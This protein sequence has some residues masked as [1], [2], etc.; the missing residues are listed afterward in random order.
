[1]LKRHFKLYSICVAI[2]ITQY[3]TAQ[4]TPIYTSSHKYLLKGIEL[5]EKANFVAAQQHFEL[6]ANSFDLTQIQLKG[7][8]EYY[9][10]LCAVEL[11]NNDAEHLMR[12]FINNYPDNQKVNDAYFDLGKLRYR[13]KKYKDAIYWFNQ[14]NR[15][16]LG[17]EKKDELLFKLGYS[18]FSTDDSENA[19]RCFFEVKD[20]YNRYAAPAT[21]YYS[22]IAYAEKSYATALKGFEKLK[23]D[24]TFASL[25]PYYISQI[26][27][28]QKEFS[29]VVEYAPPVLETA[30]PK[31]APEI[32]RI[33]GES[34]YRLRQFD[35]AVPF[36]EKFVE[37]APTLT[38]EDNYLVGFVFYRN[39]K[40][41]DAVKY[42][43]KVPT[44]DDEIS[45]NAY[46]HLADCYIKLN[47]KNK[48]RQAFSMASKSNFDMTIKEDALFNFAKITYEL[49]YNP[50]NEAIAAFN[51]YIAL[52]PNSPRIDQAYN[53]LVLAYMNTKN[54]QAALVSLDKIKNRDASI[55]QA[56]Q[57]VAFFRGIELFQ[58]LN[59]NE[60]IEKFTLSLNYPEFN[61]SLSAL[62]L[63]WRGESF[64]RIEKFEKAL[65]DYNRFVLSPGAFSLPEFQMAHYNLGYTYF[66]LKDYDNA[67]IWFRK[68][69]SNNANRPTQFLGD[70]FNRIGDSY[71]IQ[72]KYW[73][74]LDWYEKAFLTNTIDADYALFQRGFT[75]GL[76]ERPQKKIETLILLTNQ[77]PQS[78]YI[79]DAQ[80][81]LAETYMALGQTNDAVAAY[82][83]I[84]KDF[85]GSS[86]YVKALVQLG[87]AAYNQ[88][89]NQR[90]MQFYKRVVEGYPNTPEAKNALLGLRNIYVDLGNVN[91]FFE[92]TSRL[93]SLGNVSVAE[94]DSISFISSE[95]LYLSGDCQRAIQSLDQYLTNFPKGNFVLHAYYY[96]GDCYFRSGNLEKS[97][98]SVTQIIQQPKN[99]FTV[100]AILT[101]SQIYTRQ[102]RF[103]EAYE[104]FDMLEGMADAKINLLDARVG[105][106]RSAFNLNRHQNVIEAA[107]KVLITDKLPQELELEARFKR[108]KALLALSRTNDAFNEFAR[109]SQRVKTAEGSESKYEMIKILYQR[110]E[111]NKAEAEVFKFAETNT[112]HQYWLAKSFILLGDI[113]AGKNDFFQAK[114]TLQSVIDGYANANDGI[115]DEAIAKLAELV[116]VEKGKQTPM[117][118]TIKINYTF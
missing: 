34:Y 7:E 101:A 40:I 38:R 93:G 113:Y 52:F 104:T 107:A 71:F 79:D 23:D 47:E 108:A 81:E 18:Y 30:S 110:G 74:S 27:F 13:E 11:F 4:Q 116:K 91:A 73:P 15:N 114:A 57:R 19:K 67:I 97:L 12:S 68:F 22:H 106:L 31:R 21:Y 17:Q 90:A 42:F 82:G 103:A 77:F 118:D 5:F 44:E 45:Q 16:S 3:A 51:E 28:L 29:K 86:Y 60:A 54:Y 105:K 10:A 100:Q 35:K 99:Q 88:N 14:A 9:K 8:A 32:A 24:E 109:V 55:R 46:Y 94:R 96:L 6:A 70:A 41:T 69:T 78:S 36:I 85:P 92:Y 80:F 58:N 111:L 48:A 75:F 33:I 37:S 50:F 53:Y 112:P 62:G 87:L 56:Y 83:R 2:L 95:R 63:Y 25:V 72:R 59:Y 20:T 64:Y 84:E 1:M 66:K 61:R 65:N 43:E 39:E 117:R 102:Q 76:V 49:L 115:I 26:L 89:E 98:E